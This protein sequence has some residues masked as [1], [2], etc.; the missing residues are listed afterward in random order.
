MNLGVFISNN[1]EE[2]LNEWELFAKKIFP[3]KQTV[4]HSELRDHAKEMISVISSELKSYKSGSAF[5]LDLGLNTSVKQK[6]IWL[7]YTPPIV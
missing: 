1:L 6:K 5:D 2:I 7:F 4:N 3:P